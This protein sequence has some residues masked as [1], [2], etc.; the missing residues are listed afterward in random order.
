MVTRRGFWPRIGGGQHTTR[1][2]WHAHDLLLALLLP[3][4]IAIAL[5]ARTATSS[6][7]PA[8]I[9]SSAAARAPAAPRTHTI[10]PCC[11]RW[12]STSLTIESDALLADPWQPSTVLAGT[13][14]GIWVTADGGRTW[15]RDRGSP[16]GA[17]FLSLAGVKTGNA[18][19]AGDDGGVVYLRPRNEDRWR[20][21]SPALD[22]G[23]PIFSLAVS[24]DG[25]ALLAGTVGV[26]YRGV[27]RGG[28]WQWQP[29]AHTDQSS[30]TAIAFT[31]WNSRQAFASVFGS[32]PAVLR[33]DDGGWTWHA[34]TRE[35]PATLPTVALLAGAP[36]AGQ[37]VL[38]TM[39]N[40]VWQRDA[41]GRWHDISANLPAHHA[42][43]IAA[44]SRGT[45]YAGTM[46][47][48]VYMRAPDGSWQRLGH[49]MSG[50][51]YTS[52]GL[53]VA[54]GPHPVLLAGTALGVYRL[55]LTR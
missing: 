29:V 12:Q 22:G 9:A 26:L 28:H 19:F 54:A 37:I 21:I 24:S 5:V 11:V 36:G 53:A 23:N 45:L 3:P 44:D 34:D 33:S 39:G 43:P 6:N 42:M 52:L 14:K 55:P 46:G 13:S 40:G 31:P 48:G 27:P 20:A 51:Q 7:V 15:Q 49:A 16:S 17:T 50:G 10:D 2:A 18:L 41:D 38:T 35:L 25:Q 47:Y 4:L 30:V 8:R 32:A 1:D